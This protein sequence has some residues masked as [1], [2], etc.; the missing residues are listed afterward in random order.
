MKES[1]TST[2]SAEGGPGRGLSTSFLGAEAGR[3]FRD[4]IKDPSD[5]P[6]HEI[7]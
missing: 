3:S 5:L 6:P 2:N 1:I 4:L 7:V